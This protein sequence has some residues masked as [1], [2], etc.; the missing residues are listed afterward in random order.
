MG[1]FDGIVGSV[2]SGAA[3]LIGGS[4]ANSS[5][6]KMND[7]N[8]KLNVELSNTA[9]QREVADLKAA[10]LNPILS[11]GGNGASSPQM[12]AY[13]PEDVVSP[14]VSSALQSRRLSA[15]LKNIEADTALKQENTKL[16]IENQSVAREQA[17]NIMADYWLKDA[18]KQLVFQNTATAKENSRMAKV[19]ADAAVE[20][21]ALTKK[22]QA[23]GS[24]AKTIVDVAK[25]LKDLTSEPPTRRY[26]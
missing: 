1:L 5:A 14:A 20:M 3:S 7:K 13:K 18:N 6:K 26:R 2:I 22:I 10:G 19:D 15:D 4:S 11:A 8:N 16:A 21:G 23:G 24:T 17:Q 9:H 12:Q 25:V